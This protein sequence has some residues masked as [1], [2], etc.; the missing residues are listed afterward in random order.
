MFLNAFI[1][2]VGI[3]SRTSVKLRK[4]TKHSSVEKT[5]QNNSP[6]Y[7][8]PY[9][10]NIF[11]MIGDNCQLY[12]EFETGSK[13]LSHNELFGIA[14]NLLQIESGKERFNEILLM[15]PNLGYFRNKNEKYW[16]D[17]FSYLRQNNYKPSSCN[18]FCPYK[19]SCPH[20]SNII[21]TIKPKK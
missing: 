8:S 7:R 17:Q 20:S 13:K 5:A 16:F 3:H 11:D 1:T 6:K 14:T 19:N 10:S 4:N 21:S 2:F 18:T 15:Y 9:R 12:E